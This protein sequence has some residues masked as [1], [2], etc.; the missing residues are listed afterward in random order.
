MSNIICKNCGSSN[1]IVN[2]SSKNCEYCG[3]YLLIETKTSII[4]NNLTY[5]QDF[6]KIT[7]LLYDSIEYGALDANLFIMSLDNLLIILTPNNINRI[8]K[9]L[10]NVI[11]TYKYDFG[12]INQTVDLIQNVIIRQNNSLYIS[13]LNFISDTFIEK[14]KIDYIREAKN[15][16]DYYFDDRFKNI[17]DSAFKNKQSQV[18]A[19]YTTKEKELENYLTIINSIKT[20]TK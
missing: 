17:N 10:T 5:E 20:K 11:Y 13:I 19:D 3:S 15:E 18:I 4:S 9:K 6:E 16:Y 14:F 1:F 12:F 7:N 2:D 8:K